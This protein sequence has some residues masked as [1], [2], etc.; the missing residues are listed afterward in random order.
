MNSSYFTNSTIFIRHENLSL[1]LPAMILF[2]CTLS[3]LITI[4]CYFAITVNRQ[5]VIYI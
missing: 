2:I 5:K 4:I 1:Y 3:L